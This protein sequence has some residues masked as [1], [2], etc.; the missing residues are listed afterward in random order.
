MTGP[1]YSPQDFPRPTERDLDFP[2]PPDWLKEPWSRVFWC[3]NQTVREKIK[4]NREGQNSQVIFFCIKDGFCNFHPN[5]IGRE[6]REL[7]FVR[8]PS[9][10]IYEEDF[11]DWKKLAERRKV[12]RNELRNRCDR[13]RGRRKSHQDLSSSKYSRSSASSSDHRSNAYRDRSPSNRVKS[14]STSRS[15]RSPGAREK[16]KLLRVS[17]ARKVETKTRDFVCEDR[18]QFKGCGKIMSD[19]VEHNEHVR[20]RNLARD[21][22]CPYKR[23]RSERSQT[24]KQ[25]VVITL[26]DEEDDSDEVMILQPPPPPPTP[27]SPKP[28]MRE[29]RDFP[30]AERSQHWTPVIARSPTPPSRSPSQNNNPPPDISQSAAQTHISVAVAPSQLEEETVGIKELASQM[31]IQPTSS[32]GNVSNDSISHQKK[33]TVKCRILTQL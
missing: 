2:D 8:N 3:L 10:R 29:K 31:K 16:D 14:R 17:E 20:R 4:L 9:H 27:P 21:K 15:S 32:Q 7:H 12:L 26:T 30:P 5:E 13:D 33:E 1:G 24:T 19:P 25:P 11:P 6:R 23:E 28:A 22:I 18:G